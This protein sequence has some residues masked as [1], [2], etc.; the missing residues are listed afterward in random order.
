MNN[1][2]N[3]KTLSERNIKKGKLKEDTWNNAKHFV[4][5]KNTKYKNRLI[6]WQKA[7]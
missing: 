5:K 1:G 4:R 6:Y 3:L 7:T 2:D